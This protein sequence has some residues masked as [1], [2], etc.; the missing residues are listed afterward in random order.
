MSV[1]H[2]ESL[3]ADYFVSAPV[4]EVFLKTAGPLVIVLAMS[5]L[6]TLVDG[7]FVGHYLGDEALAAVSLSFPVTMLMTALST[8]VGGGM[9]SL[10]ARRL[11][12]HQY[13][14]ASTIFAGAHGLAL[15]V[16][17]LLISVGLIFGPGFLTA[18][19]AGNVILADLAQTFLWPLLLG[20]PVSFLLGVHADALRSEGR[21]QE[22][23]L[24]SVLINL[25]NIA[26][27]WL[28]LAVLGLGIVGAALGTVV[29]QGIGLILLLALRSRR[30]S[31]LALPW[32]LKSWTSEWPSL[33]GLG[34]PLC[35]GFLGLGLTSASVLMALRG[36]AGPDFEAIVAA[37]GGV[38]R[39]LGFAF[40]PALAL[41]MAS[42][43]L[44]GQAVGSGQPDRAQYAL[45]LA[46]RV[47]FCWSAAVALTGLFAGETLGR[48]FSQDPLVIQT[49]ARILRPMMLLYAVSGPVLVLALYFQA[50][51]QPGR[52]ALLTLVKPWLLMP[53]LI[54]GSTVW[55]GEPGLWLAFPMAD[56]GVLVLALWL[57]KT[58]LR[59]VQPL[60]K[61]E[62]SA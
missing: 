51:G 16:S 60:A 54:F 53:I 37:Y 26:T 19:T 9:A 46:M 48:W 10:M 5:G 27:N 23:A 24:L 31:K 7:V 59:K 58:A 14:Q 28:A 21:T 25:L 11:G 47:A 62:R 15:M 52:T 42:Q 55:W 45:K 17:A 57:L 35:L 32:T 56:L 33:L 6:L 20:S 13:E 12:A 3:S 50:L 22:I 61:V 36:Q 39:L 43:S 8:L 34:L 30:P 2:T 49:V 29:A 38:T 41:A 44:C 4:G 40:L 18:I 1:Q